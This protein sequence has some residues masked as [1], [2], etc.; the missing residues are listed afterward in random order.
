PTGRVGENAF[1]DVTLEEN[2]QL[3]TATVT[4]PVSVRECSL[5]VTMLVAKLETR[6]RNSI[7]DRLKR[8]SIRASTTISF[9]RT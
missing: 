3:V 7:N 4:R 9:W 6:K 1:A 2:G 8:A 5:S